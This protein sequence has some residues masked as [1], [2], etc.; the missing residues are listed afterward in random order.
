MIKDERLHEWSIGYD[1]SSDNGGIPVKLITINNPHPLIVRVCD[2]GSKG[3]C[4]AEQHYDI[5]KECIKDLQK[6]DPDFNCIGL[7]TD[8][9]E[10]MR[11]LRRLYRADG[12]N[13]VGCGSH[14]INK[15]LGT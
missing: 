8:N 11:K 4:G 14:A 7:C 12:G 6:V 3:K 5:I 13:A 1:G 2:T 9:E 15:A 10:T